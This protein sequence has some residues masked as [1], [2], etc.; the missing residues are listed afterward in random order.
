[1]DQV[2]AGLPYFSRSWFMYRVIIS[3][4]LIRSLSMSKMQARIAG[5]LVAV[6]VSFGIYDTT[7]MSTT[8][9]AHA[10]IHTYIDVSVKGAQR[11]TYSVSRGPMST[12]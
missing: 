6:I 10:K 4:E 8:N 5:K 7:F 9:N 11:G 12:E 1:M 2:K 3:S